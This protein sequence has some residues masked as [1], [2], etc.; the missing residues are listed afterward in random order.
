MKRRSLVSNLPW[1]DRLMSTLFV[2]ICGAL[3]TGEIYAQD[4]PTSPSPSPTP[5]PVVAQA[6]AP[7]SDSAAPLQQVVVTGRQTSLVGI[8]GSASE[9][10]VGNDEI[11]ERPLLRPGEILETVPGMIITQH[12]GGGKANQFFLRGYNLDHG[13]DFSV[14]IDGT[15]INLPSH[16]HGEGYDDLNI[17]I[18]ELVES[19]DYNKGVYNALVGDF[20]SAG[21][22]SMHYY[23]RLPANLAITT[24]GENGYERLLLA[25]SHTFGEDDLWNSNGTPRTLPQVNP[26]TLILAVEW[27]HNDGPFTPPENFRRLNGLLRYSMGSENDGFSLT[28]SGYSGALTGEN[29]LPLRAILRDEITYF[30]NL[31]PYDG[32]DSQRYILTTEWHGHLTDSSATKILLYTQYYDLDLFSDFTYLNNPVLGDNHLE[33]SE[34]V[35]TVTQV[36]DHHRPQVQRLLTNVQHKHLHTIVSTLHVHLDHNNCSEVLVV[37][38]RALLVKNVADHLIAIKGIKYGKLTLTTTGKEL[39]R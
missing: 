15:P 24:I 32:G 38:G 16:A 31:D 11:S 3:A 18:P 4:P 29:Q 36:Y 9:G 20:S 7:S 14:F 17:L 13:T 8:A 33:D 1:T 37:R 21:S 2:V 10:V 35:G 22:A 23:D 25:V 34:V 28:F 26:G 39:P 5:T 6:V 27:F 30:G 12:A 19:V